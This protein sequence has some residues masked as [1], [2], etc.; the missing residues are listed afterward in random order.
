MRSRCSSS[1]LRYCRNKTTFLRSQDKMSVSPC[2]T[3][4]T[5]CLRGARVHI[6][7]SQCTTLN[8]INEK[9]GVAWGAEK[10]KKRTSSK[11]IRT[12][13]VFKLRACA[14]RSSSNAAAVA[15]VITSRTGASD[16][17]DAVLMRSNRYGTV[18]RPAAERKFV[19]RFVCVWDLGELLWSNSIPKRVAEAKRL[20]CV[21][22]PSWKKYWC[23]GRQRGKIGPTITSCTRIVCRL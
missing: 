23:E 6:L 22:S 11:S 12:Y 2:T 13:Y 8:N 15:P 16:R 21:N 10:K 4:N 20:D 9:K 18:I 14:P 5:N 7:S 19:Y 1:C 17:A 3:R